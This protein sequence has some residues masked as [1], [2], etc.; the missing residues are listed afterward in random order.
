MLPVSLQSPGGVAN[1]KPP[2]SVNASPVMTPASG[3]P[4]VPES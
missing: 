3:W 4:K 2:V 1:Q